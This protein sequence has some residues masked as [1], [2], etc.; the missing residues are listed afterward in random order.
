MWVNEVGFHLGRLWVQ[1]DRVLV[2]GSAIRIR[3]SIVVRL[4]EP[5]FLSHHY[6]ATILSTA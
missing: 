2:G 1:R 3:I 6:P 4:I 5:G